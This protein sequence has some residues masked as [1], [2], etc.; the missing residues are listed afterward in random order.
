MMT[1]SNRETMAVLMIESPS[2]LECVEEIAK[3]PGLDVLS[4]DPMTSPCR[5]NAWNSFDNTIS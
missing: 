3:L 4:S 1:A 2:G 5:S